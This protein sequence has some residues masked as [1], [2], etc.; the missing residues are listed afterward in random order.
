[1]LVAMWAQRI[2]AGYRGDWD[3]AML[4]GMPTMTVQAMDLGMIV[5]LAIATSVLVWRR[6]AWGYLLAPVFAVKGVT[7]AGAICAMLI[8]AAV[9]EGTLEVGSFAVFGTATVLFGVLAWRIL[10]SISA[11]D[12][13]EAA[14]ACR[15][16]AR[17]DVCAGE[18]R[19]TA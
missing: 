13:A 6:H 8:S 17:R 11:S 16:R 4:L 15:D 2:A 18:T 9:V 19:T 3:T 10:G 7:M 14:S 12:A 1:M 5:P